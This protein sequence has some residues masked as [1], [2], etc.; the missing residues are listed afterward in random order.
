MY[1]YMFID[2]YLIALVKYFIP[3]CQLI[4]KGCYLFM[5]KELQ[6]KLGNFDCILGYCILLW[7]FHYIPLS[8]KH[9]VSCDT[10]ILILE[11]Q[12]IEC[13]QLYHFRELKL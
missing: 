12:T 2:M 10:E 6:Q 5:K 11:E 7:E 13:K 1:V 9:S 4:S 8:L 3:I